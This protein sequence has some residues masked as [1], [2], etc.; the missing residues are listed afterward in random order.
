M[1]R[2]T[3]IYIFNCTFFLLFSV[4][5]FAQQPKLPFPGQPVKNT[6]TG[7][8][9]TDA[10]LNHKRLEPS[11]KTAEDKMNREI[12]ARSNRSSMVLQDNNSYV[13][14][15]VF[16]I[17][18]QD[19]YAV[20]DAYIADGLKDLNDAFSKSGNYAASKGADTKISFCLAKED[21]D[22][23]ITTG[24][25][26]TKSYYSDNLDNAIED[27][28]LK[29]LIQ[30]DPS[31]YINIWLVTNVN[32]ES[33]ANFSCGTWTRL[34]TGA[35]ATLPPNAGTLDGIVTPAFGVVMAHE[36]GH[37]LG[38][39]HTFTFNDCN[40]FNCELTGDRICDTP[41]DANMFS[42]PCG[43][44]SNSCN[45]DTLSGY[46]NGFYKTDVP[47]QTDN[48]MD[49]G[50]GAC[51]NRFTEG[52]AERMRIAIT[53]QRS[54]LLVNKCDKPCTDNLVAAFT[55]DIAY[56][57]PGNTI[58]FSNKSSGGSSYQWL[59]DNIPVA[60]TAD[61]KYQFNEAG[62]YKVTLKV[63]N[64]L[65]CTAN[66]TDY[67]IVNCG[68]AA[69][70]YTDKRT[71]ASKAGVY[72]DS[73][74]FTNTSVNGNS[75]KWLVRNDA[76][77]AETVAGTGVNLRYT[78][79]APGIYY[80]R[81]IATNGSCSDTTSYYTVPVA[82]PTLDAS[83]YLF[84]AHCYETTKVR[85]SF[86]V[87]NFGYVAIPANTPVSF[88]DSNPRLAG[89]NKIGTTFY[90]PNPIAGHC[91]GF[92]YTQI[93]DVK[94]A[95]LNQIWA[96]VNDSGN[97]VPVTLPNTSLIETNF[98]NNFNSISGF[99]FNVTAIPATATLEPG[100][101]IQLTAFAG[102][103]A[104]KSYAWTTPQ[105]LGCAS[106]QSTSFIADKDETKRVVATSIFNCMDT[107][108]IAVLVPPADDFTINLDDVQ[109]TGTDSLLQVDFTITNLFK[110]GI[111]PKGLAV[112][113]YRGDPATNGA[114]LLSPVFTVPAT[115]NAKTFSFSGTIKTID[116]GLIYV[117]VN[118]SGITK[119]VSLP[120]TLMLEKVYTNNTGSFNYV[121][122]T[123][124][125]TPVIASL[126]PGDTIL[127]TAEAS[128]GTITTYSWNSTDNLSCT[129]CQ[130]TEL[131]AVSDTKKQVIATNMFGC[132]DT[133]EVEIKVPPADDFTIQLTDVQCAG[134]D[135]L[136]ID[137]KLLNGFKRGIIPKGLAVSFYSTD[138][139]SASAVLLPPV[140]V[141]P[142]TVNAKEASFSFFI[143]GIPAGNLYAVVND[144][145]STKPVVLP[146]TFKLEKNYT[147]NFLVYAYQTGKVSIQP[148][149]TTVFRKEA[150]PLIINTTI[151]NSATT[152]WFPASNFSLSCTGCSTPIVTV[153]GNATVT[154][155]TA[156]RYGCIIRGEAIIKVFPPDMTV[157][158]LKT[159]CYTNST[160]EVDFEVCMN[161]QYDS[162]W[163]GIPVSFYD[164][165]PL[166][167]ATR[168]SPV[169]F[170]PASQP[171]SCRVFQH[172]VSTPASMKLYAV[173]NDKGDNIATVP[174]RIFDE[175]R[176]DNN[177][178]DSPVKLVPF[179]VTV[180][181]ADTLLLRQNEVLL[182]P[183]A[184]GGILTT[185]TWKPA[186]FLS[187]TNCL[188]TIA[189]PVYTVQYEVTGRN[190]NYCTDT[191]TVWLRT[192]TGTPINIPSGFTPNGDGLND[193]FYIM[194]GI[195]AVELNDFAIFNR[196]GE[197]IFSRQHVRPNDPS[198][199]WNGT[200]KGQAAQAGA[201]V[202][203][204]SLVNED[205]SK[206]L[207]KG[208][209]VLVR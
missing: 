110:R 13:L 146:N 183:S 133:T 35:Y 114:V 98:N 129:S 26:R 38:L 153:T 74:L 44:P 198:F 182:V 62:K 199:G 99:S 25:T 64:N 189:R 196:Y 141:V 4:S 32:D 167:G 66:Y 87:C 179:T 73:I 168:L 36:M 142:S 138:P 139:A 90:L 203:S 181:P 71:I 46:S 60:T 52:Q 27:G 106:C 29:N 1:N 51:Q 159:A 69:R 118:D 45:T 23:G 156:N 100:D 123:V 205:G 33:F 188:N 117:V 94:Q 116:A 170:T 158:I 54:G 16:H 161:N 102:P 154:M 41:P 143:K 108:Y 59:V 160:I 77:M 53:T 65:T 80:I 134:S 105:N 19:P 130:A 169:F 186:T 93:I 57:L 107:A 207:Y 209:V 20:T 75:F 11:F 14:P 163:S 79:P 197:K 104:I 144:T 34:F 148:A 174:N 67:I 37:Y 124:K 175:T 164:S 187:C 56:P 132:S 17:I 147:N 127:L 180:Q 22:G 82:D 149:D 208:T 8:C 88:Y 194:S 103:T 192:F 24:I 15:V 112:S 125:A 122:L 201:Y 128:P 120:N 95:G 9:G 206:K 150:F 6:I 84:D 12:A 3:A 31:R 178:G 47:D 68:V 96:V 72:T 43:S 49:Y 195:Q 191:A 145:G 18:N 151:Y 2:E 85:F 204:V 126:E 89:A 171:G 101:T 7:G 21:P 190:E 92:A 131:I 97:A 40:N 28:R 50:N 76:G 61:F 63:Y 81:L 157:R 78:F 202:Y 55:R 135:S 166:P 165:Q 115:I 193:I 176:Y 58:Q 30:W 109:C 48:F 177:Y 5:L 119:P 200:Y 83:V 172:V 140:F 70:F 152:A 162:V 86:Y 42:S 91:C 173:V 111:I 137:F 39:Y 136:H 185:A 10:W 121:P 155:Q 113:F 184:V